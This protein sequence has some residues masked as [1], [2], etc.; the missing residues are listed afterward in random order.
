MCKEDLEGGGM[1]EVEYT[2]K[3]DIRKVEFSATGDACE[4]VFSNTPG[5][6]IETF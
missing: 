2:G 3:A 4:A 6:K 1:G 5:V